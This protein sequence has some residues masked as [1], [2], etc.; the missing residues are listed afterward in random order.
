MKIEAT[1]EKVSSAMDK[2]RDAGGT[3]SGN[4]SGGIV[5]I[6]GVEARFAF[7]PYIG[8]LTITIIDKPWLVSE[9]FV[10]D[11]IRKFFS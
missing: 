6:K 5:C 3:V 11:E 1:Q 7:D 8:E 9:S 2:I 4:D 10:E